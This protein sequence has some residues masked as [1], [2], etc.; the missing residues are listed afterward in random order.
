MFTKTK[1]S[2]KLLGAAGVLVAVCMGFTVAPSMGASAMLLD[3][4]GK[5]YADY[6]SYDEALDAADDLNTE[7]S[8]EGDVLLKNDGTLPMTTASKLSVFGG[9][10]DSYVGGSGSATLTEALRTEG[11]KVNSALENY[12]A[13]EKNT[14][15]V[16]KS[17]FDKSIEQTFS[18]YGDAAVVI[19]SRTGGE[20]NDLKL[21]TEEKEDNKD[22]DGNSY[23][24]EHKALYK[25]EDGNEYKHYLQLTDSEEA[26]I[27]YVKAHFDKIV[28]VLNTSNVMEVG[29]LADD[30]AINAML[31]IGRPGSTGIAGLAQILSGR[32]NPSGKL[33]DEW[34][35]DLTE[36]PTWYNFGLYEQFGS[37]NAYIYDSEATGAPESKPGTGVAGGSGFFGVDYEEGIYLGYKYVETVYEELQKG[38]IQYNKTTD[39]LVSKSATVQPADLGTADEWWESA[40]AYPFGYGLSY[41]EF[42][43]E[44]G[45]VYYMDGLIR[46]ELGETVSADLFSS[47]VGSPAKVETLYAPVTVTNTGSVAGKQVVQVY[48]SMPYFSGDVEKASVNLVGYAKTAELK[49]GESQ[50]VN[51]AFNV[52]DFASF[53]YDDANGNG[54]SGYELDAG[55][56]TI[57]VMEDS[58]NVVAEQ[59]FELTEDALLKADDFSGNEAKTW[60]SNGD[61]YDTR[62]MNHSTGA[63]DDF[64]K[65]NEDDSA[66]MVDLSRTD[67][68]ATFPAPMTEADRTLTDEYV[69]GVMFWRNF[70][71]DLDK[72]DDAGFEYYKSEYAPEGHYDWYKTDEELKVLMAGWTQASGHE[73]DY[74][75][76][77]IKLRD[78]AGIDIEDEKWDEFMNQLTLEEICDLLNHGSHTTYAIPSID[79]TASSDEN[80]PNSFNGKTWCDE[81]VVSSTWNV[82]LAEQYGII[83][84]NL[85]MFKGEQGWYG[86]GINTHRSPFGGRNNEYYSQDGIQGGYIAAAVV[87]GAQSRGLNVWVKHIFM[88]DQE[89]NRNV[90]SL[91]T[92]CNEQ[93][94]REIYA[95]QF[96]MAMQ[97]G[98]ATAA[99]AA[100]NRIGG[101]VA[102]S[103]YNFINGLLRQE[104]G[105]EG[106]FVTDAYAGL[107]TK[108]M[109]ILNR[110]G[111]NLP[112]GTARSDTDIISGVWDADAIGVGTAEN[113][114]GNVVLGTSS[115]GVA[116]GST[117]RE[118][119]LQWYIM[120]TN[121]EQVLY[122]AANTLNNGNGVVTSNYTDKTIALQQGVAASE[123]SVAMAAEDLNG[124]TAV[125][126]VTEGQLPAGLS[127]N[128]STGEI[129]GTATVSGTFEVT[130]QATVDGWVKASAKI[131][132]NISS[133]FETEVVQGGKIGEEFAMIIDSDAVNADKYTKGMVYSVSSGNLPE[134]LA[135]G[136]DGLISGTP[137]ES[138]TFN[139]TVKVEASYTSG[140]NTVTD[141]YYLDLQI[142]IEGDGSTPVVSHGDIINAEINEDGE[143]VL[144]YEDGY[145]ANLGVVVGE[146]GAAGEQGPQGEQGPAGP[147]G[148]AGADGKDGSGCNGSIVSNMLPLSLVAVA[149]LAFVILRRAKRNKNN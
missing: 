144:T 16:E 8:G 67:M 9:A 126:T 84:A 137:A 65:I 35:R 27:S 47:E 72:Y 21:V 96:Q 142:V 32:I 124:S 57:K 91:F 71:A 102:C 6:S 18:L 17:D 62:R 75:D 69:K 146:D 31:W 145:V 131:T 38:T 23:D 29:N 48:M 28:V 103:N 130:V 83:N 114:S 118:S 11:F 87:G 34:Y 33:V 81:T 112:D 51:V 77:T 26:L 44:L 134:G 107:K 122:V 15:G 49:P 128:S 74:S 125:Y 109:D 7:I 24:W 1:N 61:T 132:F 106:E 25:D 5:F 99:M 110:M 121:A 120:R 30:S 60:F 105:W 141:T 143:L 20:G 90:E 19:L 147:A 59:S 95:K 117:E 36:D 140:R 14:I 78:M 76:V 127:L 79:K 3:A 94:I 136:N 68:V 46:T 2:K 13:N 139:V 149:A 82:D 88:N 22:G 101:V 41:T 50:T 104:W 52:Q 45:K 115:T 92:W 42:D 55:D 116:A 64:L 93:A 138:G 56:Y 70:D 4:E 73:A 54:Y 80:G 10:Q 40:V 37:T 39:E 97:E 86:P 63:D 119:L 98:G 53:D 111:C 43:Y 148:P 58:H 108:N 100:F 123:A 66:Q 85:A 135:L 113:P 12:Y 133:A 129:T 89:T